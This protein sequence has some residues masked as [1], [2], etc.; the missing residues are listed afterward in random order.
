MNHQQKFILNSVMSSVFVASSIMVCV[1]LLLVA[2]NGGIVDASP[3]QLN[4]ADQ[5]DSNGRSSGVALALVESPELTA[6]V[7]ESLLRSVVYSASAADLQAT[8][9]YVFP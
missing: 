5:I 9:T 6:R 2:S 8:N 7:L 4:S 1:C 3:M